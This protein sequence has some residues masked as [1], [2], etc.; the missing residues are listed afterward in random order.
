MTN[1]LF[2]LLSDAHIDI[3]KN[4]KPNETFCWDS[5]KNKDSRVLVVAGDTSNNPYE[6]LDFVKEASSVYEHVVFI[7]GNHEHYDCYDKLTE[8]FKTVE[9]TMAMLKKHSEKLTNVHYLDGSDYFV[10]DGV[11]FIGATGWYNWK[12]ANTGNIN[13]V[14]ARI[15]WKA[16][17]NDAYMPHYGIDR[18]PASLSDDQCFDLKELV[19][20]L[21]KIENI[22]SIVVVTHM[23]SISEFITFEEDADSVWNYL[24]PS[25]LNESLKCVFREDINNKI[26][27]W[28]SGHVHSRKT[29]VKDNVLYAVNARGYPNEL[30][31]EFKALQLKL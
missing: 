28:C 21:N 19:K 12:S 24:N 10:L 2:D 8:S 30:D 17:S 25:Y 16:Y 9:E 29:L 26:K 20:D 11:A 15:M 1:L 14:T 6:T 18:S 5:F 3:W 27:I 23:P 22:E 4:N 7:D 13:E 31:G